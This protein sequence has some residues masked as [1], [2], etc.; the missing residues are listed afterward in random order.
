MMNKMEDYRRF[1]LYIHIPFCL[2]KCDYCDFLSGVY[3]S[4]D[5]DEYVEALIR[6][7]VF[8]SYRVHGTVSSVYIGGGTPTCIDPDHIAKIIE[9][10]REYYS[11][12][13]LAEITIE[14]NPGTVTE[15]GANT[16]RAVGINRVSVGLQ[17]ADN[18]ELKLLGRIHTYEKFLSTYEILR[19]AGFTNINIDI[20]TALPGQTPDK[21]IHTLDNVVALRPEH[22]SCYSLII[23]E[24]TPFYQRYHEDCVRREKGEATIALPDDDQEYELMKRAQNFLVSKGYIRY[25]ISNYAKFGYECVHNEGYWR[26][27]PYLGVGVGAASLIPPGYF[28]FEPED[29][30]ETGGMGLEWRTTNESYIYDYI[31]DTLHYNEITSEASFLDIPTIDKATQLSRREA[32][33]EFMFLGLRMTEGVKK[34]VFLKSFGTPIEK[35]YDV[36]IKK[37]IREGLLSDKGD[38]LALTERGLDISNYCMSLFLMD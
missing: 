1:E 17:S 26:R 32:M 16:Y 25:E 28:A 15:R 5:Q 18:D 27:T 6:E 35:I 22:I 8:M 2:R 14:A 11:L 4:E 21:L 9:S 33:E 23:E 10:V 30:E 31:E 24:N 37:L 3:G 34:S 12:D 29:P 20:M 36:P 19:R 13:P 38:D 7:L